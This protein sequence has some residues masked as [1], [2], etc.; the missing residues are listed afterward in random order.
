MK[1]I[2]LLLGLLMILG[3]FGVAFCA[4]ATDRNK[5]P[6]VSPEAV[7]NLP[8]LLD[9]GA[10]K[11]QAC[12]KMAPILKEL[13]VD[14]QESFAVEFIDVWQAKN[15]DQAKAYGISMIPTQVFLDVSGREIWR[16]IGFI[17]KADILRKW[18]EFGVLP[19]ASEG[20]KN[21]S[22]SRPVSSD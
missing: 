3:V 7:Q 18:R 2:G 21:G 15:R 13:E 17:S 12:K 20:R 14:Y 16:H 6:S 19:S 22:E 4:E 10:N 5:L 9:F 1:N 11:C 8:R